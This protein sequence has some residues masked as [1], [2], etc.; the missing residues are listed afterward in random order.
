MADRIREVICEYENAIQDLTF[1]SKPLINALTMVAEENKE[2]GAPIVKVICDRIKK[3]DIGKKMPSL[4][5]LDSILKNVG[6]DYIHIICNVIGETFCHV[7]ETA[8]DE[9]N[10]M[11]LFKLRKT[12]TQYF[13]VK[14]LNEIDVRS[15]KT[16]PNWPILAPAIPE[17]GENQNKIHI[18]PKFLQPKQEMS[19]DR[20]AS[21]RNNEAQM[22]EQAKM[23][24][25]PQANTNKPQSIKEPNKDPRIRTV[26]P[27]PDNS[28]HSNTSNSVKL[29]PKV[30]SKKQKA[31]VSVVNKIV[32]NLAGKKP[33]A[34]KSS[35]SA[36]QLNMHPS[37]K[38][39]TINPIKNW[40]GT[41]QGSLQ[42][43][44][45]PAG[46]SAPIIMKS[47]P[48]KKRNTDRSSNDK[49]RIRPIQSAKQPQIQSKEQPV[50]SSQTSQGP[51]ESQPP[52]QTAQPQAQL[53]QPLAQ[54]NQPLAQANQPLAQANQPSS[55]QPPPPP[56]SAAF[57]GLSSRD[58]QIAAQAAAIATAMHQ[59]QS[60]ANGPIAP[61]QSAQIA[62]QLVKMLSSSAQESTSTAAVVTTTTQGVSLPSTQTTNSTSTTIST[63]V[64][65]PSTINSTKQETPLD[66]LKE[67]GSTQS[68]NT[69]HS[70][71][72][73]LKT[74][75]PVKSES[76]QKPQDNEPKK[77][78]IERRYRGYE[79]RYKD[80]ERAKRDPENSNLKMKVD[81][82]ISNT[83]EDSTST[84]N[85]KLNIS[86]KKIPKIK[87][88]V[89]S[90][91]PKGK[92]KEK[93]LKDVTENDN[94]KIKSPPITK[95]DSKTKIDNE[96]QGA[97]KKSDSK[98]ASSS[99][100]RQGRPKSREG[101]SKDSSV[102]KTTRIGNKDKDRK[103][104][105]PKIEPPSKK[106]KETPAESTERSRKSRA[107]SPSR[108]YCQL[109]KKTDTEKIVEEKEKALTLQRKRKDSE[110]EEILDNKAK[111]QKKVYE[112]YIAHIETLESN[113]EKPNNKISVGT[114]ESVF[115][116]FD[117]KYKKRMMSSDHYKAL[118]DRVDKLASRIAGK[119]IKI[120][121]RLKY[122]ETYSPNKKRFLNNQNP[123]MQ[124]RR[125]LPFDRPFGPDGPYPPPGM[126]RGPPPP[127]WRGLPPP[128][129]RGPIPSFGGPPPHFMDG[130]RPPH[131]MDGPPPHQMGMHPPPQMQE[132]MPPPQPMDHDGNMP[133]PHQF[134]DGPRPPHWDGPPMEQWRNSPPPHMMMEG[135]PPPEHWQEMP[136]PHMMDGPPPNM[137]EGPPPNMMEGPPPNIM[138]PPP[139]GMAPLHRDSP[140]PHQMEAPQPPGPPPQAPA[141]D[142]N[143]L[144]GQLISTG[145]IGNTSNPSPTP[146]MVD[147]DDL[148]APEIPL[149]IDELKRRQDIVV[150]QLFLGMQ[151]SSCGERFP[152]SH[153]KQ[154]S[155][156]LDWHF[157]ENKK[158]K[159]GVKKVM[160]RSW[161]LALSDW[162]EYTETK[163]SKDGKV[164][165]VFFES[166][167]GEDSLHLSTRKRKNSFV[168]SV[169]VEGDENGG[170]CGVCMDR[171]E[172]YWDED[173][174]EWRYKDAI[175][176]KNKTYHVACQDYVHDEELDETVTPTIT[177]PNVEK[178]FSL[179]D[180]TPLDDLE[181]IFP[182]GTETDIAPP[183]T[184]P[185]PPKAKT[186]SKLSPQKSDVKPIE[187]KEDPL[188]SDIKPLATIPIIE[189]APTE[190]EIEPPPPGTENDIVGP[191]IPDIAELEP[192]PTGTEN[193]EPEPLPP[194]T[195]DEQ[196]TMEIDSIN[197]NVIK[198]DTYEEK[199]TN[200]LDNNVEMKDSAKIEN[201]EYIDLPADSPEYP[202]IAPT[203]ERNL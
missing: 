11:S 155:D 74:E 101:N 148:P 26:S 177:T 167:K 195:E 187:E 125:R 150:N 176:I 15:R 159:E 103:Q 72:D 128:H 149:R 117:T 33:K 22:K 16:D 48:P 80:I 175:R 45:T 10:R 106:T 59:M 47:E 78:E 1:N 32:N 28:N 111:E 141:L 113:S 116:Q 171:L 99:V 76:D 38:S 201:D 40:D 132:G 182:P 58:M 166:E 55:S 178:S 156:H 170:M 153:R 95:T 17:N 79:N 100:E 62:A 82:K 57:S 85:I 7:F 184:E 83:L 199:R 71:E 190:T 193:E 68:E 41:L 77:K 64:D 54:A 36:T 6:K 133:P 25:P 39:T 20:N 14:T 196:E 145:L 19:N 75:P 30:S 27:K 168:P 23:Q 112:S 198:K 129:W 163:I 142:V 66:N 123:E 188:P 88:T 137:N 118:A 42:S 31:A 191:T 140:I 121:K 37:S 126:M 139:N 9:R 124:F 94:F 44:T 164:Q 161:Y 73:P 21:S 180:S 151:C 67:A 24:Q 65:T 52:I 185:T 86:P 120:G 162:V 122:E 119:E 143:S 189:P 134:M 46:I 90:T 13:P 3:V 130:P 89:K 93:E 203:T 200:F 92:G 181:G 147:D 194:G 136:P 146:P 29:S 63:K 157:R 152:K 108:Y 144:L 81:L 115:R 70:K 97:V 131:F 18:N 50:Q 107:R 96:K 172:E 2:Y 110:N 186:I 169:P 84:E 61:E 202:L 109:E 8:A 174:E 104:S 183:G 114:L 135:G 56:F 87:E 49:G 197:E 5:L 12:W 51:V 192:A 69:D 91:S 43:T 60:V 34:K 4:Y 102:E 105:D 165:S 35:V 173:L 98:N 127:H 138:Q 160:S 154:Y 179:N 53:N 158:E